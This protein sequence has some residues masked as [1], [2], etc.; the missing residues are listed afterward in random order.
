MEQ[1][2]EDDT[3]GGHTP[4]EELRVLRRV[5]EQLGQKQRTVS[6]NFNSYEIAQIR[7]ILPQI[8][9]MLEARRRWQWFWKS[10]GA[11]FL[12]GPAIVALWQALLKL[13]EWIRS[14]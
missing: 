8:K 4:S 6:E 3:L 12:G 11:V 14:Q 1:A 7:E 5:V 2:D 10:I 13:I 9:E